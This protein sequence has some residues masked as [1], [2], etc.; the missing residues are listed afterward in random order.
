M[1]CTRCGGVILADE[2]YV[3]GSHGIEHR[4]TRDCD[5]TTF[6]TNQLKQWEAQVRTNKALRDAVNSLTYSH[7]GEHY[8]ETSRKMVAY[9]AFEAGSVGRMMKALADA[10]AEATP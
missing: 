3:N 10:K 6:D 2:G 8:D 5:D 4:H 7:G 1:N 9:V